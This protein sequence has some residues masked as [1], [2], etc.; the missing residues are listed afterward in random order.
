MRVIKA[1]ALKGGR[2]LHSSTRGEVREARQHEEQQKR[3]EEEEEEE[4]D[5]S[6]ARLCG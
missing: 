5:C 4:E 6:C 3:E 1:S 2:A